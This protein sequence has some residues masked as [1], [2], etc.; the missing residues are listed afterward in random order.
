MWVSTWRLTSCLFGDALPCMLHFHLFSPSFI[1]F[2]L[3][4]L[5]CTNCT[6]IPLYLALVPC[7]RVNVLIP[8]KH[9]L[10]VFWE[11]E[12]IK[13]YYSVRWWKPSQINTKMQ[14]ENVTKSKLTAKL[15]IFR[16]YIFTRGQFFLHKYICDKFYHLQFKQA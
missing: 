1:F 5:V 2:H 7:Q 3:I 10:A 4:L 13:H 11:T 14:L 8:F 15:L 12:I 9:K 16:E 6:D